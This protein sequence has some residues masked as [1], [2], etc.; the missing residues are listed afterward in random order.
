MQS[1][2]SSIVSSH[3]E[4][5]AA[6]PMNRQI[7]LAKYSDAYEIAIMARDFIE[8][9]LGWSWTPGRIVR[10]IRDLDTVVI[11]AMDDRAMVG[12]AVMHFG[13]E[14]ANLN[15]IA[16]KPGYRRQNLGRGLLS[17]LQK[18]A[19]VAGIK[20]IHLELRSTNQAAKK[21]YEKLGYVE[22]QAIAG[23]YGGK[24]NAL[25]M[26][27]TLVKSTGTI[28]NFSFPWEKWQNT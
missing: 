8:Y 18:S 5:S 16:I 26:R 7:T 17:W 4:D 27:K 28:P 24:E 14:I 12:F 21:F 11:K 1:D 10:N 19:E 13:L 2:F 6:I 25:R 3:N 9:G 20:F 23:Y 15:L 22:Y